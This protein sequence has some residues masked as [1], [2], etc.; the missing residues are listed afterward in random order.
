VWWESGSGYRVKG[1]GLSTS[2]AFA[3]AGSISAL[4]LVP[5]V[6]TVLEN[7]SDTWKGGVWRQI[8]VATVQTEIETS[9]VGAF[10]AESDE[11]CNGDTVH[12]MEPAFP[13]A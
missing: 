11:G 10:V 12:F 3:A 1:T 2:E 5:V 8:V 13:L 9:G 6:W 4:E 7:C